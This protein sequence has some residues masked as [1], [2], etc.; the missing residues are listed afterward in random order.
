MEKIKNAFAYVRVSLDKQVDSYSLEGQET[1]IRDYCK[2][3]GINLLKCYK[4][5]G[6]SGKSTKNRLEFK[7]MLEDVKECK[8]IDYVIVWKLSR[9]SRNVA[10]LA[11]TVSYLEKYNVSLVCLKDNIDTSN[12]LGKSFAYLSGIFAELDRCNIVE[13]CKMGMRQRAKDG[14]WNGGK[15]YGYRSTKD[16]DKSLEIHETEAE[17]VREIFNLYANENWGYKKIACYLNSKHL[18][19][20]KLTDWSISSIKQIIDNPIYNGYIRWGQHLEWSK[21]RRQGTQ[22][23]YTVSKGTHKSIITEETWAKARKIREEMGK[24]NEKVYEGEFLLTGLLRCP[25]C[26][27][28]MISHR[29]AKKGKPGEFYRYYQCSSFFNKGS[30]VCKSNLINA[31][32][33]EAYVLNRICEVVTSQEVIDEIVKKCEKQSHINTTPLEIEIKSLKKELEKIIGK[34]SENKQLY[35]DEVITAYTL[36]EILSDLIEKEKIINEKINAKEKEINTVTEQIYINPKKIRT[37]LE[38]FVMIFQKSNIERRKTLLKSIIESISINKGN[39][40][41]DRIINNL[42][43]YFEPE[44]IQALNSNK[45]F[46]TTYGTVHRVLSHTIPVHYNN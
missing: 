36:N 11:N 19:T 16:K 26:G 37:I 2:R 38:N 1:E 14:G 20:M 45:N 21:K 12:A 41:Q 35:Y 28:S 8:N 46:A 9:F 34:R 30:S 13:T 25:I 22:E 17:I 7:N 18:K 43:L 42:K 4:D 15:V 31:D 33:A 32:K 44:E 39:S 6:Q 23:E 27:S 29:T 10:D 5:E 24:S 40:T 3:M